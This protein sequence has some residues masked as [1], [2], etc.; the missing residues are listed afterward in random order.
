MERNLVKLTA[1]AVADA[2]DPINAAF[3]NQVSQYAHFFAAATVYLTIG[4]FSHHWA[5]YMLPVGIGLAAWKE[6]WWDSHK[7]NAATRGSD[8]ED[9][10]FYMLGILFGMLIVFV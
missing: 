8:L 4:R 2:I 3:F 10:S 6:F 7:E 5:L 1:R 9:F